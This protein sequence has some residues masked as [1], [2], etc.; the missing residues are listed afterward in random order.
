MKAYENKEIIKGCKQEILTTS[1]RL[2]LVI[3]KNVPA[4]KNCQYS[5][6]QSL[7]PRQLSQKI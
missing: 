7:T 5:E 2:L 3:G 4:D 1:P 6:P